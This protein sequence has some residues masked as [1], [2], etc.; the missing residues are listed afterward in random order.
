MGTIP[1]TVGV[2]AVEPPAMEDVR[3]AVIQ[4][5]AVSRGTVDSRE[6]EASQAM[7]DGQVVGVLRTGL[8]RNRDRRLNHSPGQRFSQRRAPS[9]KHVQLRKRGLRLKRVRS[10]RPDRL[11]PLRDAHSL[12]S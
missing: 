2:Q 3:E 11:R 1:A 8:H 6:A 5:T 9:P 12:A 10:L 7:E 4:A